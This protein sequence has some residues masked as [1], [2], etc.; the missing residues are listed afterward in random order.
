[1]ATRSTTMWCLEKKK[2]KRTP[3]GKDLSIT[4]GHT[5]KRKKTTRSAIS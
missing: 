5:I 2:K 3:L 4:S 1:M